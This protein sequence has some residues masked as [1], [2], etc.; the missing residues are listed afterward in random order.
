MAADRW[1][2]SHGVVVHLAMGRRR[3]FSSA[4]Y[5]APTIAAVRERIRRAVAA[6]RA[7]SPRLNPCVTACRY[8]KALAFCR[9]AREHIMDANEALALFGADP[10]DRV[11]LAQAAVIAKRFAKEA[12]E[13]AK[14]WR[15]QEAERT[16]PSFHPAGS[17]T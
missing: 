12:E 6:A 16:A 3:E 10:A 11:Q 7:P 5:D 2:P 15:A 17:T 14:L 9:A 13:L 1:K 4:H 8:C